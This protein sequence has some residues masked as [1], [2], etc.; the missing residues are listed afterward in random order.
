MKIGLLTVPFNNNYGGFLQAFALKNTLMQ[1]GHDVV[2]LNRQRDHG[3]GFK[4]IAYRIL[5]KMGLI[6][7]FLET[8]RKRISIY[9]DAFKE[10]YLAPITQPCY[11]TN[12]LRKITQAERIDCC[13]VGSDQVWRYFYALNSLDDYFLGFLNDSNIIR[14][15]YSASFGTDTM[16]YP[17][18]KIHRIKSLLEQ[19]QGIS[20]RESSGKDLLVNYLGVNRDK[21]KVVLDPTM[22]LSVDKY[23]SLIGDQLQ[24][25][26]TSHPYLFTYVLDK[27]TDCNQIISI[28]CLKN[29]LKR[30]DIGAETG[31]VSKIDVIE[32]VERWLSAISNATFVLTDSFHGTVF[33]IL[34]NRPFVV[35]SNI[36]RGGARIKDL[37][38]RFNLEDRLLNQGEDWNSFQYNTNIDWN[39]IN[40]IIERERDY[41]LDFLRSQL[42]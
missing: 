36:N 18:K 22:L 8:R 23:K 28:L 6:N 42:K 38:Q 2:F 11:S 37:L 40:A 30:V 24:Q 5:V 17:P 26:I 13:I 4:F 29:N 34:F 1:M 9:T 35:I 31:D 27:T 16:D 3:K 41:S 14:F 20:V 15:S 25:D 12:T 33:S 39:N 10:K 21:I 7:D 19:F 32:P